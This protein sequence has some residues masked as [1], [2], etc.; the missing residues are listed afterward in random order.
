MLTMK[1][2]IDIASAGDRLTMVCNGLS[3]K[4]GWW[5]GVDVRAPYVVPTKLMLTVSEL[6]EAMEG[7]RKSKMDE[8]LTHRT[9]LEVE[10][11]DAVIRIFDLAGQMNLRLGEA[12][13]EKLEYN[14]QRADHKLENRVKEGGKAY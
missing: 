14:Q 9:S 8:H 10:L 12:I 7:H 6:G 13:A 1:E 2:K 3:R 4:S 5:E 11:A